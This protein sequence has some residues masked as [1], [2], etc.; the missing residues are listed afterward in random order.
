MLIK[1]YSPLSKSITTRLML[2]SFFISSLMFVSLS[3]KPCIHTPSQ[4]LNKKASTITI[5]VG[6][7]R[8]E[9]EHGLDTVTV[10]YWH[11]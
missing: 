11:L 8:E 3:R 9:M 4:S 5:K 1:T 2:P 6:D 7:D 10:C